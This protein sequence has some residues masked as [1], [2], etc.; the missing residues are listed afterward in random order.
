MVTTRRGE[1]PADHVLVAFGGAGGQHACGVAA[2]LG[3]KRVLIPADAGLLS[4]IG[5][6]VAARERS[7]ESAILQPLE[8]VDLESILERAGAEAFESARAVGVSAPVIRRIQMRVRLLGQDTTIDLE[9]EAISD[10][11]AST[12]ERDFHMSY[13]RLYGHRPPPR[14]IE[15]AGVTDSWLTAV[16][17]MTSLRFCTSDEYG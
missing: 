7:V 8:E 16:K 4:A 14:A 13:R 17:W 11:L 10:V 5:L 1:D 6:H 2:R 15:I 3:M 12:I 9:Y